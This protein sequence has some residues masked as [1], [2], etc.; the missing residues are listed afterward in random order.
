MSERLEDIEEFKSY[1]CMVVSGRLVGDQADHASYRGRV[2]SRSLR[3][4]LGR[5]ARQSSMS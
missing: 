4:C 1:R 5:T 2:I 3:R